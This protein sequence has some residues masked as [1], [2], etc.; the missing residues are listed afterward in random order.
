MNVVK[1]LNE[2]LKCITKLTS[3]FKKPR[4]EV[5]RATFLKL[6]DSARQ[7]T[8]LMVEARSNLGK[9][10]LD[11]EDYGAETWE[12][13]RKFEEKYYR[14][15]DSLFLLLDHLENLAKDEKKSDEIDWIYK[16][17]RRILEDEGI[18][19]ILAKKGDHFSGI[20][21]KHVGDRPDE[22]PKGIVLEVVRK[23]YFIR[24]QPGIDDVVL[25]PAETIISSGPSGKQPESKTAEELGK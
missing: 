5:E 16:K 25:R 21:H 14:M 22:L 4:P 11:L 20:Y 13:E 17:T 2:W 7:L 6:R 18:E 1:I 23:G 8:R 15:A 24:S 19:E 10:Q 3:R 12:R 9:L